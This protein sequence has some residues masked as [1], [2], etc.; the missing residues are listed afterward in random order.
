MKTFFLSLSI[1]S[2]C[3]AAS[4]QETLE[5]FAQKDD[6]YLLFSNNGFDTNKKYV[7]FNFWNA[8]NPSAS[9]H[10]TQFVTMKQNF[11]G[12]ENV[13]FVNVE[14]ETEKD[15]Q[16]A[17]EKYNIESAVEYGKHIR[18]KN[19]QFTLN[20][21]STNA[22]FLIENNKAAFLCSGGI[23]A[24]KVKQFFDTQASQ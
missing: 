10:N 2:I 5:A 3:V 12:Q 9:L 24:K 17:L 11:A 1:L 22:F 18:L 20:T 4:A 13:E 14:W 16:V 8:K 15:V 21:S 7:L 23:C 19:E 6:T